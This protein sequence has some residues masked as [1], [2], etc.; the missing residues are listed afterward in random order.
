MRGHETSLTGCDT[1]K[2]KKKKDELIE[3][4]KSL[5]SNCGNKERARLR[6]GFWEETDGYKTSIGSW[7]AP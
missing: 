5:I 3:E 4:N 7:D 6:N 2:G 1:K